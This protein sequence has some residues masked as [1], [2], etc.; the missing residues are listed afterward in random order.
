MKRV[1]SYMPPTTYVDIV[2]AA[3]R[4]HEQRI[5]Q[6]KRAAKHIVA[7]EGDLTRLAESRIYVDFD[8]FSMY[9]VDCRKADDYESRSQ[10]ALRI[11]PS[12]SLSFGNG[13]DRVVDGFLSL[14]WIVDRVDLDRSFTKVILRR[15]KTQIRLVLDCSL[16]HAT[17][18]QSSEVVA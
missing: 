17:S 12:P 10:W 8:R 6:L 1:T 9:L 11:L 7:I 18:L 3:N 4:Q 2:A 5:A 13:A 14:G 15:P 16:A